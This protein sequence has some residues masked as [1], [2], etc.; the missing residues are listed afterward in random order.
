[1][2]YPKVRQ[3]QYMTHRK[4]I[5]RLDDISSPLVVMVRG[6]L[7]CVFQTEEDSFALRSIEGEMLPLTPLDDLNRPLTEPVALWPHCHV[8]H[9]LK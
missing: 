1:M 8:Q 2:C 5:I 3:W 9:R 7:D 4:T 6:Q